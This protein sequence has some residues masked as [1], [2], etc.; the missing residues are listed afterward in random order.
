MINQSLKPIFRSILVIH[1]YLSS[2]SRKYT[3]LSNTK[4]NLFNVSNTL[5]AKM[6]RDMFNMDT[7]LAYSVYFQ[8][9]IYMCVRWIVL[10]RN[11]TNTNICYHI[12]KPRFL[13]LDNDNYYKNTVYYTCLIELNSG[14]IRS[15]LVPGASTCQSSGCFNV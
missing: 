6:D 8:A 15:T 3:D 12:N 10:L 5:F 14:K 9:Y 2:I 7:Y 11:I 1:S 4:V 13:M